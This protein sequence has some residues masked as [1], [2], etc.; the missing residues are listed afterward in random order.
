MTHGKWRVEPPAGSKRCLALTISVAAAAIVLSQCRREEHAAAERPP[1]TVFGQQVK[2]GALA[3][4]N[5]LLITLDTVRRDHIGCYGFADARTPTIDALAGRGILFDHAMTGNPSTLPSHCT[6]M[7]GLEIPNHGVRANARFILDQGI[8]TLAEVLKGQGY[9][10]AAFIA[11]HVLNSHYGLAQGFDHYD[12]E[13]PRPTKQGANQPF[14]P[15]V[16]RADNITDASMAWL[17]DHLDT[18][19]GKQFF[20]WVHYFDAH[21]PCNPPAKFARL[22]PGRPYDGEIAFADSQLHRLFDFLEAHDLQ[23]RTLIVLASDHGEG[24]GDHGEEDHSRLIYDTTMRIPLIMSCPPVFDAPRRVDDVTVGTIDIMPT[25]LSLLGVTCDL[26]MDGIDLVTSTVSRDRAIY[27]E[28]MAPFLNHG[29]ASL[30]GWRRI[31]GKYISAPLPEYYAL[32]EDPNEL[33][34]LLEADPGA[35]QNYAAELSVHME[36]WADIEN[37]PRTAF[38]TSPEM[39]RQLASLGYLDTGGPDDIGS[40]KLPDPKDM[41]PILDSLLYDR[42]PELHDRSCELVDVPGRDR[43]SYR[44]GR[45]LVLKARNT[46]PHRTAYLTTLGIAEFRLG[47]TE[48]A[49]AHLVDAEQVRTSAGQ[50]TPPRAIAFLA[51]TLH[52]L[53]RSS[54]AKSELDRLRRVVQNDQ[55]TANDAARRFLS[56]AE[57]TIDAR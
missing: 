16:R 4:F 2:P 53:G 45:I 19:P 49:L 28:T 55:V 8:T 40:G 20:M 43:A 36:Q 31:Q 50:D 6:I 47:N 54:E 11:T 12:D 5:L 1:S 37:T 42:P 35:A 22:F 17:T 57:A 24:L 51:M 7:T 13:I 34:N 44:R 18:R 32:I 39:A 9:N 15:A 27:L 29:W 56:E 52:R 10:T 48:A 38:A 46:F 25:V 41:V 26:Q 14:N 33:D 23:D 21:V 30:H 3:G